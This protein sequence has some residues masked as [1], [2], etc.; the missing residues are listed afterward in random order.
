MTG[1]EAIDDLIFFNIELKLEADLKNDV[2]LIYDNKETVLK[3]KDILAVQMSIPYSES[4]DDCTLIRFTGFKAD[5]LPQISIKELSINGYPVHDF[6]SLLSFEMVDN[7]FVEN[8]KIDQMDVVS[9]NGV[10]RLEKKKNKD[11]MT[12]FPF[13]YSRKRTGVVY[14]NGILN[15]LSRYGCF[16]GIDCR[17]DPQW[18]KFVFEK[19]SYDMVALGC[20]ITAGSGIEKDRTWPRLFDKTF[21][22]QTL[23]LG[24]PGG[25][26]DQILNNVKHLIEQ[27]IEFKKLIILFPVFGR[28]LCRIRKYGLF[29]NIPM[30][31]RGDND[32]MD[33]GKFNIF[34]N[35]EELNKYAKEKSKEIVATYN[36]R[37]DHLIIKRTIGLLESHGV[38][39]YVSS[40][41]R[42][43][44]DFLEQ[45]VDQKNLLPMFNKENDNARGKDGTHPAESIHEKWVKNVEI[46]ID[47]GKKLA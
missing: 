31:A 30:M 28:R 37:R 26:T 5:P 45:S 29:F 12:W 20:S 39:F 9:F 11:R 18:Q 33:E 32:P 40:W 42:D 34:F 17:H 1:V 3:N 46:Q 43:T 2:T 19:K 41:S 13:T 6:R 15:C 4:Q 14:K 36:P 16:G 10:L 27:D 22:T 35:R 44:F 7:A 21:G 23:N 8:K 38:D 47:L 25:G 24:V